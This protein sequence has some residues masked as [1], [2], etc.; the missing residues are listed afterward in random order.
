[1][2]LI[3][4]I[5]STSIW[6][7][8]NGLPVHNYNNLLKINNETSTNETC[9]H[10]MTY[11]E[12]IV[13]LNKTPCV[14]LIDQSTEHREKR[15]TTSGNV[16]VYALQSTINNHRSMINYLTNNTVNFT[17]MSEAIYDHHTRTGPIF[18]SCRDITLL[19]C[20]IGC[21]PTDKA[22]IFVLKPINNRLQQQQQKPIQQ[23]NV[24][25][26]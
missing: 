9:Y 24:A 8:T 18:T 14:V 13:S 17:V 1:M 19:F 6:W 20:Y 22:L 15:D 2:F 3:I 21:H 5:F 12:I 16:D 23:Q 10:R 11:N 4:I 26:V 7:S 25:T